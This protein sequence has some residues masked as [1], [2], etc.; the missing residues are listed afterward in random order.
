MLHRRPPTVRRTSAQAAA[1]AAQ[2]TSDS[3]EHG[4]LDV[5]G[6][7]LGDDEPTPPAVTPRGELSELRKRARRVYNSPAKATARSPPE[8]ST[9]TTANT[10]AEAEPALASARQRQA[11]RRR[12]RDLDGSSDDDGSD[13]AWL[14]GRKSRAA[15][16]QARK[17]SSAPVAAAHVAEDDEVRSPEL[18][19]EDLKSPEE[20][21]E[22]GQQRAGRTTTAEVQ[23]VRAEVNVNVPAGA[24]AQEA[25]DAA[26]QARVLL[27]TA[28]G[29]APSGQPQRREVG[30]PPAAGEAADALP[31]PYG[32][33]PRS[34]EKRRRF[35]V[36]SDSD[37]D[38]DAETEEEALPTSAVRAAA[39]Q[40]RRPVTSSLGHARAVG[41]SRLFVPD[42]NL[43]GSLGFQTGEPRGA[44]A[45]A[46]PQV[47]GVTTSGGSSYY[48]SDTEESDQLDDSSLYTGADEST[49]YQQHST[50][51]AVPDV[52]SLAGTPSVVHFNHRAAGGT[53][54][55]KVD[56]NGPARSVS[57]PADDKIAQVR[58]HTKQQQ[59]EGTTVS[60]QA[61]PPFLSRDVSD[62]LLVITAAG[63][64]GSAEP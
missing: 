22:D 63:T 49:N 45:A 55:E 64:A 25:V 51:H 2:P 20:A 13:G 60:T 43:D 6:L 12:A 62:R 56:R 33:K 61:S 53:R 31:Q 48:A 15:S 36:L 29:T 46:Q 10:G 1:P 41:A 59:Q 27:A 44:P 5:E 32:S 57:W 26:R 18:Q 39:E 35:S 52:D 23:K 30:Q 40:Q 19:V 28:A 50:R 54:A 16:E 14:A 21:A 58:T 34:A 17:L 47:I 11:A 38:S 3:A 8:P 42:V 7:E 24:S 4:G 37:S 9:V